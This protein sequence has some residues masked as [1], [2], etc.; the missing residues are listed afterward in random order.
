MCK[1][2]LSKLQVS[3]RAS[4]W[5]TWRLTWRAAWLPSKKPQ[6]IAVPRWSCCPSS[7]SR[8]TPVRTCSGRMPSW[9]LP[10][11]AW[12]RL[13]PARPTST[14]CCCL[15]CLFAWPASSTTAPP[16]SLG[17]SFWAWCPSATCPCTTS[18]TR[19]D[20]L[21]LAPRPSPVWTLACS[22]RC[23]LAPTSCLRA[24]PFL[25]WLWARRSARTSGCPCRRQT[26][27]P[28]PV[29]R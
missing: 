1:T 12:S 10:S 22:A 26:R 24:T 25:N 16:F 21:F 14:R 9:T 13:P 6:V 2:D 29:P 3:R 7:A 8:A 18:F 15:D 4:A 11:A 28:S 20:T 27:T 17:E 5:P 23:R 19:A